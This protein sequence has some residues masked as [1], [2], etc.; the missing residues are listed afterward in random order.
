VKKTFSGQLSF[1]VYP[2]DIEG[3]GTQDC[4]STAVNILNHYIGSVFSLGKENH[5]HLKEDANRLHVSPTLAK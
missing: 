5:V 3:K 1:F 2:D 4:L